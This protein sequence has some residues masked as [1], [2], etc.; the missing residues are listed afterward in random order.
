MRRLVHALAIVSVLILPFLVPVR[1]A[2]GIQDDPTLYEVTHLG[3]LG[4]T[5]SAGNSI[6]RSWVAGTS[7]LPGDHDTRHAVARRC[8]D[9]S[10]DAWWAEQRRPVAREERERHDRGRRRDSRA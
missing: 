1:N 9:R 5:S 4:G 8:H 3:S 7:N 6:D 2:A 10:R